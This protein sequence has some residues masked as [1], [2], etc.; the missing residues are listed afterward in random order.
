MAIALALEQSDLND[1]Q[2]PTEMM[3][4]LAS[5]NRH[6][7]KMVFPETSPVQRYPEKAFGEGLRSQAR[8]CL[9]RVTLEP[10]LRSRL[11]AQPTQCFVNCWSIDLGIKLTKHEF[12][13]NRVKIPTQFYRFNYKLL[14]SAELSLG[15]D[16]NL[17]SLTGNNVGNALTDIGGTIGHAL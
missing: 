17:V 15:N 5:L 12:T 13:I 16:S 10:A 2:T 4:C 9:T 3:S 6:L 11:P 1:C 7:E 14:P 8:V